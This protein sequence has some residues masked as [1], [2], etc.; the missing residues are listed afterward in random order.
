MGAGL[1]RPESVHQGGGSGSVN[2]GRL[3]GTSSALA[4][5]R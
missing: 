4:F 2:G 1:G 3:I 5:E